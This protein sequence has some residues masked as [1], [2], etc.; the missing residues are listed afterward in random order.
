MSRESGPHFL[1]KAVSR[2]S[3]LG[4]YDNDGDIDIVVTQL[5]GPIAFLRNE[6]GNAQNWLRIRTVGVLSNRD[7]VG[8]RLIFKVGDQVV[9][10]EVRV[11]SSYL[12]SRDPRVLLG[13]SDHEFIDKIEVHWPSGIT[14]IF[15]DTAVN[16]QLDIIEKGTPSLN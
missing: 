6:N 15:K 10:R 5:N 9:I 3:I 2:G 14:Q 7:G 4:D 11:G 8:T 16:Q 13:V 12:C 1:E